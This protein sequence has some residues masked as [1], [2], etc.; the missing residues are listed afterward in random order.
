[1]D[2]FTLLFALGALLASAFLSAAMAPKPEIPKPA[3]FEDF[4]FPRV[5]E[6]TP[7]CVVF[8]DVWLSD[9]VV[10]WYGNYRIE[11]IKSTASKKG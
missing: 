7:E 4:D 11:P 3:A 6:G 9:W 10:L 1:M 8:G 2:P 5:E